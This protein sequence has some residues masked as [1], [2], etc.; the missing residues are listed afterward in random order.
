[1]QPNIDRNLDFMEAELGKTEWFAGNS[2]TAAD[3]Q[4]SFPVE[5]AAAR[6]GLDAKRPKLMAFLQRI[7]A[8][9]AYAR[10]L[11]RGGPYALLR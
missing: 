10:A 4:M 9:P 11:Q 3:V 2:F 6:G 1:M 7:H 8:R 5:G